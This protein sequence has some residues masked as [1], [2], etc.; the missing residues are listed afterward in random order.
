ML[1][2]EKLALLE[3]RPPDAG[4]YWVKVF[5]YAP[6]KDEVEYFEEWLHFDGTKWDYSGY[7][8][9]YVCFISKKESDQ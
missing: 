9:V 5:N 1:T 7:P 4:W 8:T 3:V 2:E 6:K